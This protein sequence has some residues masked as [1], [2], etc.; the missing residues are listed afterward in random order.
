MSR[1]AEWAEVAAYRNLAEWARRKA[2]E[3]ALR[4]LIEPRPAEPDPPP[5]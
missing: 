3:A 4:M 2:A 1:D 5:P